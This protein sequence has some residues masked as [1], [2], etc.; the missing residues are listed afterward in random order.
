MNSKRPLF[1]FEKCYQEKK[2]NQVHAQ[3]NIITILRFIVVTFI[4]IFCFLYSIHSP[5]V[6]HNSAINLVAQILN[7]SNK[8]GPKAVSSI[9]GSATDL[10]QIVDPTK[11][12]PRPASSFNDLPNAS[13]SNAIVSD[14][15][16]SH[17]KDISAN[18]KKQLTDDLKT[19]T[20][21]S[22][23]PATIRSKFTPG[24]IFKNFFK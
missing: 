11:S 15:N 8:I 4:V 22:N 14:A 9:G 6:K 16:G 13:A 12:Y 24:N 2:R 21:T 7:N 1:F 18:N 17:T 23:E 5:F 10:N 19:I 3:I 20:N